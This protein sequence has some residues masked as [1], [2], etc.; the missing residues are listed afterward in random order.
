MK[1]YILA[2]GEVQV[3]HRGRLE[4]AGTNFL[5]VCFGHG[6]YG[7]MDAT[8]QA[9]RSVPNG[10]MLVMNPDQIIGRIP[11]DLPPGCRPRKARD[12]WEPPPQA[13]Q[14]A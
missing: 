5:G 1:A 4:P 8:V 11:E 14:A 6:A 13:G 10:A 3:M 12:C 7:G 2:R 9:G